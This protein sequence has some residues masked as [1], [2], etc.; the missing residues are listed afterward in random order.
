V[1]IVRHAMTAPVVSVSRDATLEAALDQML[2]WHVSG[3]PVVDH[4]GI[5][6]G[7]ISESDL[8]RLY[9]ASDGGRVLLDTCEQHMTTDLITIQESGDMLEATRLLLEHD[10]RRLMVVRGEELVGVIARR[11]VVRCMRD[12]G[13]ITMNSVGAFNR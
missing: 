4:Q 6:I 9:S 11:D 3:L 5:P 12:D 10:V 1:W 13:L 7:L 8:L 2:R